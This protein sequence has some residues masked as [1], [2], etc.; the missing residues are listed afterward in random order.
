MVFYNISGSQIMRI[1]RNADRREEGIAPGTIGAMKRRTKNSKLITNNQ[2]QKGKNREEEMWIMYK[3]NA[4]RS[5]RSRVAGHM[6]KVVMISA[7]RYPGRT[8]PGERPP[9]PEGLLEELAEEGIL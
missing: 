3:M 2:K 4:R 7:W 9:I 1:F 8:K 6:S 5:A